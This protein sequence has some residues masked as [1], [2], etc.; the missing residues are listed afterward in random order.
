M[1]DFR[2]RDSGGLTKG[3]K[4]AARVFRPLIVGIGGT[5]RPDS[6]SEKALR[7]TLSMAESLGAE[8]QIFAGA[9]IDLP[10][11]V[12]DSS[13]RSDGAI[14]LVAAFRR[15]HG[16][17]I[18][19][20]GYHGSISGLLKNALDYAEDMRNDSLPYFDGRAVALIAC[21]HGWQATGTTLA[22][23]RSIV[24]ALRGWPTPMGVAINTNGRTF[25]ASGCPAQ[26]STAAQLKI[27]AAQ[28]VD[29]SRM[30][31]LHALGA[32]DAAAPPSE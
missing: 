24:H 12:P 4:S 20:P 17:V 11:Y 8:T 7:Y 13:A 28:V 32:K 30:R 23:L 3:K 16:I 31:A 1:P 9:S 6:S 25:D 29:F 15:A 22:A 14:R 26:E 18:S 21:A 5:T 10:M 27:L 2:L 19:S